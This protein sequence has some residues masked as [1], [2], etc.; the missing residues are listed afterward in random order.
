[1]RILTVLVPRPGT[2]AAKT[3]LPGSGCVTADELDTFVGELIS[4]DFEGGKYRAGMSYEDKVL[5]A[6]MRLHE[7]YPT[8][9][10]GSFDPLDFVKVGTFSYAA[11]WSDWS[12]FVT[13]KARVLRWQE[14]VGEYL[15]A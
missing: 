12:L 15:K 13:D 11:D 1:M 5:R 10:R 8:V 14:Q 6:A 4:V 7:R 2:G 9:A 3:I